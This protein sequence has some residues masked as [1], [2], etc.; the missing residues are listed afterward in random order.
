[1]GRI[2][3][4]A[5]PS[6]RKE[7]QQV[8]WQGNVQLI[9]QC[10]GSFLLSHC[11]EGTAIATILQCDPS[12]KRKNDEGRSRLPYSVSVHTSSLG[13]CKRLLW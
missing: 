12:I 2:R 3:G 4:H 8:P 6:R 11:T 13:S 7:W 9:L 10:D 1:M 5:D